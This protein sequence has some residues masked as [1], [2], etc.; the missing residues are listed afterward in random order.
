[1]TLTF[2]PGSLPS[3]AYVLIS[4]STSQ[5]TGVAPLSAPL[6]L[7]AW[8]ASTGEEIHLFNSAPRQLADVSNGAV[9]LEGPFCQ[10]AQ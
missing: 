4:Y 9:G 8:N 2:D 3:D 7:H 5:V 10:D 6:A 1:M